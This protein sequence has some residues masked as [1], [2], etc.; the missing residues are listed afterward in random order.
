MLGAIAGDIIGWIYEAA[1]IKTKRFPLFGPGVTFTDDTC[2]PPPLP[3]A[4]LRRHVGALGA[5]AGHARVRQLE[6]RAAMRV[7]AIAPLAAQAEALATAAAAPSSAMA[8]RCRRRRS[9]DGSR[10]MLARGG[11]AP[12]LICGEIAARSGYDLGQSVEQIRAWYAFDISCKGVRPVLVCALEADGYE[13]AIRN[14]TS[15]GG[16]SD[17]LACVTGGIAEALHG[18]PAE[19]AEQAK[20]YLDPDLPRAVERFYRTIGQMA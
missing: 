15:P 14:A 9:G 3:R 18:L 6:Q 5:P 16:D 17:T 4:G 10:R 7:S 20:S 8:S 19:V 1:P 12:A 13:D 11:A 2:A